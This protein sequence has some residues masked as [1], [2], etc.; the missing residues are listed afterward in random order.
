MSI[1]LIEN[2]VLRSIYTAIP[3]INIFFDEDIGPIKI[4][5]I[6]VSC[7]QS[8]AHAVLGV[9]IPHVKLNQML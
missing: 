3:Y 9:D 2:Q 5:D 7:T 6:C 1:N 4:I 8:T